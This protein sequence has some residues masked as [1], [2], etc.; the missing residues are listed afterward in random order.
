MLTAAV[1]SQVALLLVAGSRLSPAREVLPP[2]LVSRVPLVR[3][4][5]V[6]LSPSVLIERRMHHVL[7]NARGGCHVR[8]YGRLIIATIYTLQ[9]ALPFSQRPLARILLHLI[10]GALLVVSV[11]WRDFTHSPFFDMCNREYHSETWCTVSQLFFYEKFECAPDFDL[12]KGGCMVVWPMLCAYLAIYLFW[13]TYAIPFCT[14]LRRRWALIPRDEAERLRRF[15]TFAFIGI[16]LGVSSHYKGHFFDA[17]YFVR[18]MPDMHFFV[19][20]KYTFG[21]LFDIFLYNVLALMAIFVGLS[22]GAHPPA[23][24]TLSSRVVVCVCVVFR[25]TFLVARFYTDSNQHTRGM[26]TLSSKSDAPRFR[27]TQVECGALFSSPPH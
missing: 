18:Q 12:N 5:P 8:R 9:R 16:Y 14:I 10:M 1:C 27:N 7:T 17:P 2:T 20:D 11:V 3:S 22:V 24:P 15:L 4:L 25:R 13:F 26:A 21:Q 23:Q 19:V 6:Y